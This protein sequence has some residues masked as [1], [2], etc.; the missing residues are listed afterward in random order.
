MHPGLDISLILPLTLLASLSTST[1]K[2]SNPFK[3]SSLVSGPFSPT[4]AVNTIAS[5]PPIIAAYDPIVALTL[6]SNTLSANIALGSLSLN[7]PSSI[8]LK[9]ELIPPDFLFIKSFTS[10]ADNPSS[11]IKKV[12]IAGSMLP[13]L[14]PI[15]T[16]SSGVNPIDVSTET[17]FLT[18]HKLAPLPKWQVIIFKSFISLPITSATFWET[19]LWEVP[20]NPYFLIPCF[21]YNSYGKA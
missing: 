6:Y 18:A 21:W 12:T 11:F 9:S 15:A 20:W 2:N 8:S 19:Y 13:H 14:V 1:P 3:H 17:P 7:A 16:P 10:S 5:T 4:P